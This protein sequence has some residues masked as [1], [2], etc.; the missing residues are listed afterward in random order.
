M[1]W[2]VPA[3]P[4]GRVLT[5]TSSA[6][7]G[8]PSLSANLNL[9]NTLGGAGRHTSKK[10]SSGCQP[11]CTA[12]LTG[13]S[14]AGHV[15]PNNSLH[16]SQLSSPTHA[17]R[18][19]LA[20]V[21]LH[22]YI[23]L[24][25]GSAT[26]GSLKLRQAVFQPCRAKQGQ[27]DG[28]SNTRFAGELLSSMTWYKGSSLLLQQQG[29]VWKDV[30][31]VDHQALPSPGDSLATASSASFWAAARFCSAS[32]AAALARLYFSRADLAASSAAL[33]RRL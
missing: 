6:R 10:A 28:S 23:A 20:H 25:C 26:T 16:S 30:A 15:S 32:S 24:L 17:W 31:A 27:Q 14:C 13:R 21:D 2:E 33:Q 18:T 3:T 9:I 4:S 5:V 1:S 29:K 11:C 7:M 12:M 22:K 19:A 8:L